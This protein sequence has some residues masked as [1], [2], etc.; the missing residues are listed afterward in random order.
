MQ[1][2]S[3]RSIF[4]RIDDPAHPD[5]ES[6][7]DAEIVGHWLAAFER[8]RPAFG[9]VEAAAG[10]GKKLGTGWRER[11]A[12]CGSNEQPRPELIFQAADARAEGGR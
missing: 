9:L 7:G 4:P 1:C 8:A 12:S 5:F 11:N 6:R 10:F 3:S 2:T